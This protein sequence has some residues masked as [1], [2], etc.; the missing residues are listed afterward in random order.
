MY[1]TLRLQA[2]IEMVAQKQDFLNKI[3]EF[4]AIDLKIQ[5]I[6]IDNVSDLTQYLERLVSNYYKFFNFFI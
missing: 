3:Q 2:F 4:A 6:P 1:Q 5:V